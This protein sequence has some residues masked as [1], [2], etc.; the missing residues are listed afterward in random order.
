[1]SHF[2]FD[3]NNASSLYIENIG[4]STIKGIEVDTQFLATPNT[5]LRGSVQYLD[6]E[7]D[8]FGFEVPRVPGPASATV[9]PTLPQVIG[10]P[11]TETLNAAGRPVYA[12]SCNGKPGYNAPKWSVNFGI[13]QT[14]PMGDYKLV[15]TGDGRY[16]SDRIIGFEQLP[17]QHSGSDTLFDASATF[18]PESGKWALGAYIRNIGDVAVPVLTQY[19]GSVG[20]VI[21]TNYAAPRTFGV[22]GTVKF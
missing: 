8:K 17:Q 19:G 16:R 11:V 4:S 15:L 1:M 10:C 12:V 2:G 6:N 22:R 9:T 21:A 3:A 18:S 13:E 7:L 14:I 20:G 5:L